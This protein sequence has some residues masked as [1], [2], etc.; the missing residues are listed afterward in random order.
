MR[1][2]KTSLHYMLFSILFS[3]LLQ[4]SCHRQENNVSEEPDMT[5]PTQTY[6]IVRPDIGSGIEVISEDGSDPLKVREFIQS[7]PIPEKNFTAKRAKFCNLL[8]QLRKETESDSVSYETVDSLNYMAIHYL[9]DLLQDSKSIAGGIRHPMLQ[10]KIAPDR[11]LRVYAWDEHIAPGQQ[12]HINVFQYRTDDNRLIT[13]FHGNGRTHDETDFLTGQIE[14]IQLLFRNGDSVRLY[15]LC[16]AGSHGNEHLY[17]GFGCIHAL[18]DSL[19]F[20]YPAFEGTRPFAA[21]HYNGKE[22]AQAVFDR[23][24]R[25]V[26]LQRHSTAAIQRDSLCR[27]YIFDGT[28]FIADKP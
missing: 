10:C 4:T 21:V 24:Q 3:C 26:R 11:R 6:S 7:Y 12:S 2:I 25:T 18:P 22:T 14:S 17:K 5:D 9:S 16:Y 8:D 15:L 28:H 19:D 27:G 20:T 23:T 1:K 13:A